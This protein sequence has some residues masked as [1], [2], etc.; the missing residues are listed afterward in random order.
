MNAAAALPPSYAAWRRSSRR[1]SSSAR[2]DRDERIQEPG[3]EAIAGAGRVGRLEGSRRDVHVDV[4]PQDATA[5]GTGLD[6]HDRRQL[7]QLR[8]VA[9]PDKR[10][11]LVAIGEEHVALHGGDCRLGRD[12]AAR[13][14]RPA[15]RQVDGHE[16]A[17][18]ARDPS[19]AQR[20]LRERRLQQRVGRQVQGIGRLQQRGVSRMPA[21][22][23][24]R[25][26]VGQEGSLA[27]RRQA[28]PRAEPCGLGLSPAPGARRHFGGPAQQ[29]SRGGRRRPRQRKWR[30]RPIERR[31][32]PCSLPNHRRE[33]RSGR[34][35][36][37]RFRCGRT[38]RTTMSSVRS[39]IVSRRGLLRG[40]AAM[41]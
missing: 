14:Q 15:R 10:R 8:H 25:P 23:I 34:A 27:I 3:I 33:R 37:C 12:R 6:D 13:Q 18:R 38:A 21:Q 7:E 39:P 31:R 35:R 16:G 29:S 20:R 9:R 17:G 1:R 4:A 24:G 28:R 40:T 11:R 30:R 41:I 2:P 19:G 5:L 26:S 22:R 32:A 36:R